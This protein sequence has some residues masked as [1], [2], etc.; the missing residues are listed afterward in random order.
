MSINTEFEP[1]ENDATAIR[2]YVYENYLL[3][4][5]G[6]CP[7]VIVRSG[8][9]ANALNLSTVLP[10]VCS[11]L[12]ADKIETSYSARRVHVH[13]PL[14]GANTYFVFDISHMPTL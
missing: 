9:V 12:G 10:K 2:K 11:A 6:K 7:L 13:G 5:K 8:D 1:S 3:P 4:E 14:N